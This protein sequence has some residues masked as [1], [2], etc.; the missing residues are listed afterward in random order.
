MM[1]FKTYCAFPVFCKNCK[2]S[3]LVNLLETTADCPRCAGTKLIPY[4][5]DELSHTGDKT[6]FSW[7]VRDLGRQLVLTDGDYLCPE[8][9]NFTMHS[10]DVGNWD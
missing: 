8:C 3:A 2:S 9:G 10:K 1:N 6:I 4:D 7:N 5:N